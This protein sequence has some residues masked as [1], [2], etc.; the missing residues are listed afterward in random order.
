[1]YVGDSYYVDVVG[2]RNVGMHGVLFDPGAC[3]GARDCASASGLR[4]AVEIA[5]KQ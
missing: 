2:S 3:W 5:L 1:V 4:A